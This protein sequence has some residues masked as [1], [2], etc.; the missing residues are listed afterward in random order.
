MK[1][2][3][4]FSKGVKGKYFKRYSAG[5]NVVLIDGDVAKAFPTSA[6]VNEALRGLMALAEKTVKL[7]QR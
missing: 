1:N 4:D 5:T 6:A 7:R 2:E 3:Y